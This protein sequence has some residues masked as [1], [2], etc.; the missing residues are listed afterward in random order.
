MYCSYNVKLFKPFISMKTKIV[1]ALTDDWK[2]ETGTYNKI[3][4]VQSL[5]RKIKPKSC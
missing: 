5:F 3:G 4:G 2:I 1:P